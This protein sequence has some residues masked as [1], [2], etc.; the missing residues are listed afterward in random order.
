MAEIPEGY[1]LIAGRSRA[2]A[3]AALDAASAAGVDY[4]QVRAVAE[5]YIA[6][7][8]VLDKYRGVGATEEA[9]AAAVPAAGDADAAPT[10]S[11]RKA[12]IQE[13]ADAHQ[14]DLDGATTKAEMLAAISAAGPQ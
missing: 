2:T 14:I 1:G 3:Q 10:S 5:G 8:A 11:S 7:L 13:W 9:A 4:A 6:P 12:E